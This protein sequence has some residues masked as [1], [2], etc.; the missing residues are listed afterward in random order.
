MKK[1]KR[2]M[3]AIAI[4]LAV[5]VSAQV[6]EAEKNLKTLVT[7]TVSGW[8]LGGVTAINAS[9]TA[10]VNWAAGGEG[11]YAVNGIFS[12]H[13]PITKAALQPGTIHSTLV[14]DF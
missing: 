11:S 9:Q 13:S 10:L 2:L 8:R 12:V 7:D 6:T 4:I 1:T 5:N 3:A 14:M